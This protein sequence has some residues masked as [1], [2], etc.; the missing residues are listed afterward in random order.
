MEQKIE[1]EW[2]SIICPVGKAKSVVVCEWDIFSEEGY[3]LKR[4]LKQID[5]HNPRLTELGGTDC[6]WVC[7]KAIAK[8]EMKRWGMEWLWVCAILVGGIFWIVFYDMYI[9]PYLHLYGLFLFFGLPFLISLMLYYTWKM[10][11]HI[12]RHEVYQSKPL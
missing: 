2:K 4:T 9:R 10:M 5:C 6:S 12:L 8:E 3:I 7:E 11:R 1:R